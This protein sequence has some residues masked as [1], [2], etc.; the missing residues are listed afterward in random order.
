M[1][2]LILDRSMRSILLNVIMPVLE[3]SPCIKH[4]SRG[5][6][7]HGFFLQPQQFC[8]AQLAPVLPTDGGKT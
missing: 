6:F 1:L 5:L 4:S 2:L 7:L 8:P 3:S